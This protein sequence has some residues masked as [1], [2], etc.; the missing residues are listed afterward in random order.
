M[1]N[2]AAALPATVATTP[3]AA[4]TAQ[5][6]TSAAVG[7]VPVAT[8]TPQ[9]VITNNT[10]AGTPA[11]NSQSNMVHQRNGEQIYNSMEKIVSRRE[12]MQRIAPTLLCECSRRNVFH[13]SE[14]RIAIDDLRRDGDTAD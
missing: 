12:R 5:P 3:A 11:A 8:L 6:A 2:L 13:C 14:L 10:T 4:A 7:V 1:N 9:A